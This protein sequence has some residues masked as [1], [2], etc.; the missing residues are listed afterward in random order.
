MMVRDCLEENR[1]KGLKVFS[2][3]G[4]FPVGDTGLHS[5]FSEA[6]GNRPLQPNA[7]NYLRFKQ[8]EIGRSGSR[9]AT[10]K[11]SSWYS[12]KW[13][14]IWGNSIQNTRPIQPVFDTCW[15]HITND[16]DF[17]DSPK[18]GDPRAGPGPGAYGTRSGPT[19]AG[20]GPGPQG[21]WARSLHPDISLSL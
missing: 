12:S 17:P 19:Q 10:G 2:Q 14:S 20:G 16:A 6:S 13:G 15:S 7:C 21:I 11:Y 1:P 3:K 9:N 5:L 8:Q 18:F 4:V